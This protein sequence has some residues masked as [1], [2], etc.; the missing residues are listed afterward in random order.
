MDKILFSER[1][2][3]IRKERGFKSQ[4]ALAKAY[5]QKYNPN[6]LNSSG[7]LGSIKKWENPNVETLPTLDK[8]Y[9]L[10]ELLDC[11]LNYL[12]GKLPCSTQEASDFY[13]Q[14]GLSEDTFESLKKL[15]ENHQ[16]IKS[17]DSSQITELNV[18]ES[19]INQHNGNILNNMLGRL[20]RRYPRNEIKAY[21]A[22]VGSW[23]VDPD[24]L[25]ASDDMKLYHALLEWLDGYNKIID[26]YEL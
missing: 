17:I 7:I 24:E 1:L 2:Q 22:G 6:I 15:Y 26:S 23:S 16:I 12:T 20:V 9:N 10:C 14:T 3:Q 19:I 11:D 13:N 8:I 21:M 25:R 18:L 4:E 5:N